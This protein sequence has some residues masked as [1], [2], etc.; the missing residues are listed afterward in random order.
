MKTTVKMKAQIKNLDLIK[1]KI[2]KVEKLLEE[3]NK[4]ELTFGLRRL[5]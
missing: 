1:R 3:I 4:L 2:Q 5:K